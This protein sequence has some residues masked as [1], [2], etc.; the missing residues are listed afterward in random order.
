MTSI[1]YVIP[2]NSILRTSKCLSFVLK[3]SATSRQQFCTLN[4]PC[5][6]H[7]SLQQH[8]NQ[9]RKSSLEVQTFR[10]KKGKSQGVLSNCF[11]SS[12]AQLSDAQKISRR[13]RS[14]R[15]SVTNHLPRPKPPWRVLFFGTDN[16]SL[17]MLKTLNENRLSRGSD[18]LVDTL[19]VVAV[20][21]TDIEVP[22]RRYAKEQGLNVLDWQPALHP[23]TYDVG[24]LASFGFLIPSKV[25]DMF[26]YGILNIHPSLLPRWRG[27]SPIEHTILYGDTETGISIMEI[28]PKHFDI[29]PILL[30]KRYPMKDRATA[31]EVKKNMA[32]RGSDVMMEALSN[33]PELERRVVEQSEI[34]VTYAHKLTRQALYVDWENQSYNSIDRQQ[35]ALHEIEPLRSEFN[36]KKIN[37]LDPCDFSVLNSDPGVEKAVQQRYSRP[38]G[39]V[40]AGSIFYSKP[41][42]HLLVKCQDGWAG[43]GSIRLKKR[44]TAVDFHSGYLQ[45]N[46][47]PRLRSIDNGLQFNLDLLT[48][49]LLHSEMIP[50][51]V[52]EEWF[53]DLKVGHGG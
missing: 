45:K 5:V 14:C 32:D 48:P 8:E 44:Q 2:R 47:D 9:V 40:P 22:V 27:A 13:Q 52:R 25:I 19:E 12:S 6:V 11:S 42:K 3:Q 30:Q 43:F 7:Q 34:G 37:L 18:R 20:E 23:L 36:N 33:L 28:R 49:R 31:L 4:T 39:E 38:S 46:S 24:V 1:M 15:I 26:P 50:V 10:E 16:F 53:T 51:K 41:H 35:R 21:K 17:K 29:G